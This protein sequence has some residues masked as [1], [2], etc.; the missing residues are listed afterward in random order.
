MIPDFEIAIRSQSACTCAFRPLSLVVYVCTTF[1]RARAYGMQASVIVVSIV[2]ISTCTCMVLFA[3]YLRV[4]STQTI[5]KRH[6]Y[7]SPLI[8]LLLKLH[9][10]GLPEIYELDYK[11][12]I[13]TAL[14]ISFDACYAPSA[15]AGS[16]FVRD[17]TRCA[18]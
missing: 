12:A 2:F 10:I 18:C 14:L 11:H 3:C 13:V 7:H 15:P 16:V 5:P 9:P 6:Q 17:Y 8:V 1:A 4:I